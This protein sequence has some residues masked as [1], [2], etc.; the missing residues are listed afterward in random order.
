M[1]LLCACVY[2]CLLRVSFKKTNCSSTL[3]VERYGWGRWLNISDSTGTWSANFQHSNFD[4]EYLEWLLFFF[5]LLQ[6]I[7]DIDFY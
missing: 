2:V 7:I 1:C 5:S 6:G 3:Y 4:L